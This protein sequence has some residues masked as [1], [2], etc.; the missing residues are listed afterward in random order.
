M[1]KIF[2]K[3][4][5]IPGFTYKKYLGHGIKGRVYMVQKTNEEEENSPKYCLR[6]IW[7]ENKSNFDDE[8]HLLSKQV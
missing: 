4:P 7:T 2:F 1:S 3:P 8:I 6:I 5:E